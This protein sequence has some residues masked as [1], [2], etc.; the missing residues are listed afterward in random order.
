MVSECP[1]CHEIKLCEISDPIRE[2]EI[3]LACGYSTERYKKSYHPPKEE[4]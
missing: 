4:D 3:C 1:Q 2:G